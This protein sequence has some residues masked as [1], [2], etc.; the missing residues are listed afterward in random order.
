MMLPTNIKL[1]VLFLPRYR[2]RT[3]SDCI[4]IPTYDFYLT[5]DIRCYSLL[6]L[7]NYFQ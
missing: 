4:F 2:T 1:S 7:I 5:I 6:V 3:N